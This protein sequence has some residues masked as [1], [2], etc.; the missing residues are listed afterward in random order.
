MEPAQ[1][2]PS[3]PA[4]F[5]PPAP[6][7][8]RRGCSKPVV[9]GCA[10]V[11]LV[12]ALAALGGLYYLATHLSSILRHS[13]AQMEE[14]VTAN[15][16]AD[17]TP[18][19]RQRLHDAFAAAAAAAAHPDKMDPFKLQQLQSQVFAVARKGKDLTRQDVLSLTQV[20]EDLGGKTPGPPPA[21]A[22]PPASASP[23]SPPAAASDAVP[24]T[25]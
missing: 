22:A 24:A 20:L 3:S 12:G 21:P 25:S 2:T 5:H 17:V 11:L 7:S 19:E 14:Q 4:P 15:L 23:A 8:P 6:G 16:P 18:A 9:V 1:T 10:A 13:F